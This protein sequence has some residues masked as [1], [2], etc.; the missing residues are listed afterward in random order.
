LR[1]VI[2]HADRHGF[3]VT[4]VGVKETTLETVFINLT[5]RDLRE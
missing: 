5:G 2:T 3:D 4:D 1:D